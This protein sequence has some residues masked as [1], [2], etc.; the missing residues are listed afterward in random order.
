[1]NDIKPGVKTTEFFTPALTAVLG[2]LVS[3]GLLTTPLADQLTSAIMAAVPAVAGLI[4]AV[5][6]AVEYMRGR[7]IL[8]TNVLLRDK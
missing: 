5:I 1:M 3:L 6:L 2:L 7:V 4:G 8:K